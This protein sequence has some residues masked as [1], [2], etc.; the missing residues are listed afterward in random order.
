VTQFAAGCSICG[1]DLQA[2]RARLAARR[3]PMARV[4]SRLRFPTISDEALRVGIALSLALFIPFFGLLL[5]GF[6]AWQAHSDGRSGLR[7]ALVAVAVL[8]AVLIAFAPVGIW[9]RLLR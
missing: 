7:N 2:A 4:S 5:A 9:W 3:T 1:E 6:L 8:A